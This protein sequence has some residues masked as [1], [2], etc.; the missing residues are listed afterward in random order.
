[1]AIA[2][3]YQRTVPGAGTMAFRGE[4]QN[5]FII[6]YQTIQVSNNLVP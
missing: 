2:E 6:Q 5:H 4:C 1:M 3:A